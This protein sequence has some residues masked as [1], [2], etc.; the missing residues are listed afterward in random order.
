MTGEW[1]VDKD[2]KDEEDDEDEAAVGAG[3]NEVGKRHSTK[4]TCREFGELVTL[5]LE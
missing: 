4:V 1:R 3:L 5:S 2:D